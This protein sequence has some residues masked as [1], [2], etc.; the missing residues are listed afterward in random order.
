MDPMVTTVVEDFSQRPASIFDFV[1]TWAHSQSQ[2]ADKEVE[3]VKDTQVD[4]SKEYNDQ[5]RQQPQK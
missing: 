1:A 2:G 3:V 4:N 5:R